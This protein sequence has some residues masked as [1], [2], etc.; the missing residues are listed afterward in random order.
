MFF[1]LRGGVV[2][3]GA[4]HSDQAV[5]TMFQCGAFDVLLVGFS[6]EH[7]PVEPDMGV[8]KRLRRDILQDMDLVGAVQPDLGTSVG[9]E[10]A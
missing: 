5:G 7:F 3:L 9:D 8:E 1:R 2:F 6:L 4:D 10:A